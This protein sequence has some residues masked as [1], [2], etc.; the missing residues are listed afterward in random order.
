MSSSLPVVFLKRGA[1]RRL[2]HG[3][4]W[5]YSNEIDIARGD[6]QQLNKGACATV[7]R[8]GG[9]ALGAA[10]F[11]RHS[12]LCGRLYTRE[13]DLVFDDLLKA[14]ILVAVHR[15]EMLYGEPYYRAVYGDGDELSGLIVDRYG[16]CWVLQATTV[17]VF[18]RLEIIVSII[19]DNFQ[20]SCIV[21]HNESISNDEAVE[22]DTRLLYGRIASP[23]GDIEIVEN[24][25]RFM[26]PILAGQKTGWFYDHR[27]SR[28]RLAAISKGKRVL[29]VYS[30]LGGWGLAA[31]TSGAS[32]MHAIDRSQFALE[33]LQQNA[34]L[35]GVGDR[36]KT[37]VGEADQLLRQLSKEEEKYDVVILDPPAFIKRRKDARNGLKAYHSINQLAMKL[38]RDNGVLASCS[39]S[40]HLTVEQLRSVLATAAHKKRSQARIIYSGGLGMDH[41]VPAT[42]PELGY[43]KTNF[44]QLGK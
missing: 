15:R 18:S 23:T 37:F 5:I 10:Y 4:R 16:D 33:K 20:P 34:A 13:P 19:C 8:S 42:M 30:Y 44:V 7:M 21:L 12:L 38:L 32:E 39:C 28:A 41:P 29:D 22:A 11:N 1:D 26:V 40:L 2:T 24:G 3:H 9:D 27:E 36:C 25:V 17:G 43:L 6:Y 35:N 14:R 31:L